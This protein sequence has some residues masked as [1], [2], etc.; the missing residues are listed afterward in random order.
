[1]M[2]IRSSVDMMSAN[3]VNSRVPSRYPSGYMQKGDRIY[4]SVMQY[5]RRLLELC[6]DNVGSYTELMGEIRH[7]GRDIEGLT[8]VFIRNQARGWS[9]E[10]P[11]KF[12]SDFPAP[13][14][15]RGRNEEGTMRRSTATRR[16][17]APWETH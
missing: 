4:V 3:K 6:V 2:N 15:Q 5:G 12:Y 9:E 7:A 1:M 14:R 17:I 8:R 10:R 16:M 13:R 11:L